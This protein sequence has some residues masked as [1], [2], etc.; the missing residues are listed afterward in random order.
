MFL[1]QCCERQPTRFERR[2]ASFERQPASFERH[3]ARLGCAVRVNRRRRGSL[4]AVRVSG[5]R[6]RG[7][8]RGLRVQRLVVHLSLRPPRMC[9]CPC[10][11]AQEANSRCCVPG[12]VCRLSHDSAF[13]AAP[14]VQ[15]EIQRRCK[16][17]VI[18]VPTNK[19]PVVT[20]INQICTNQDLPAP[21]PSTH[22][23]H[24]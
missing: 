4:R 5:R 3:P 12:H 17:G 24:H 6:R 7:W 15:N 1:V 18:P 14:F 10:M 20:I 22:H 11:R 19:K 8:R 21:T 9:T 2:P 23:H 13:A 16:Q